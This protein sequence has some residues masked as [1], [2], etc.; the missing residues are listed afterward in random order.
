MNTKTIAW[1]AAL[2]MTTAVAGAPAALA[3]TPAPSTPGAMALRWRMAPMAPMASQVGTA[4]VSKAD[5]QVRGEPRRPVV[6]P[7]CRPPSWRSRNPRMP[8]GEGI[9]RGQMITDHTAAI[10]SSSRALAQQKGLD[11][12]DGAGRQGPEGNRQADQ[13]GRQAKF[14]KDVYGKAR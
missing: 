14:D 3:Q 1:A 6:W 13:A 4:K 8:E 5:D 7:K 10:T 11:G 12:A 2:M 9:S